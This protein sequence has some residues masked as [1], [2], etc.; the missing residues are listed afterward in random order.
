MT[1]TDSQ[2]S[3]V[4]LPL[5]E[6]EE[7][8][9]RLYAVGVPALECARAAGYRWNGSC[10][11]NAANARRLAQRPKI[12]ARIAYLRENRDKEIREELRRITEQR[13]MLWHETDIGDY[14][15]EREE[16]FTDPKGNPVLDGEGIPVMRIVQRLKPFSEL[17]R[18]QRRAVESLTYTERG[19]PNLKLHS[20]FDANRDLR[21]MN[22]LDTPLSPD[23]QKSESEMS[24]DE[25][26]INLAKTVAALANKIANID[27]SQTNRGNAGER[28]DDAHSGQQESQGCS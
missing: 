19:R 6:K 16:P 21:K 4:S 15:E 20:A 14:Y 17:T 27:E 24:D 8:F 13:L 18:E 3:F 12:R 10:E 22:G 28:D 26:L 7:R 2:L 5:R 25:A 9:A 1:Q 23:Q 11:G